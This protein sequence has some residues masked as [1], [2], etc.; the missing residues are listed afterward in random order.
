MPS[1]SEQEKFLMAHWAGPMISSLG[2]RGAEAGKGPH[3]LNEDPYLF[4]FVFGLL[5]FFLR[6]NNDH[7]K[8]S[9]SACKC[10]FIISS[11]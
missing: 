1:T 4:L 6:C 8:I 2:S 9:L 10:V 7:W 5:F 11:Y 3:A